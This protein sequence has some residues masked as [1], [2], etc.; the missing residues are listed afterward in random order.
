M[1]AA[2]HSI[3]TSIRLGVVDGL[4]KSCCRLTGSIENSAD[5]VFYLMKPQGDTLE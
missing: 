5:R 2:S 1:T 3:A 4:G